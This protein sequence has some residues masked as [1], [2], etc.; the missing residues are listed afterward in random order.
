MYTC[1][2]LLP[3]HHV[4]NSPI[5]WLNMIAH[6]EKTYELRLASKINDWDLFVGKRI[7]FYDDYEIIVSITSLTIY[8]SVEEAFNHLGSKLVSIRGITKDEVLNL[9]KNIYGD[10]ISNRVVAIGIKPI[11]ICTSK[12]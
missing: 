2:N 11:E 1:N 4:S 12:I 3:R 5:Q 9:Y 8:N 6:K 10:K 7:I